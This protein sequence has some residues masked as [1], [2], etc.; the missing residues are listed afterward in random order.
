MPV[1]AVAT[2]AALFSMLWPIAYVRFRNI[3]PDND[4]FHIVTN[5]IIFFIEIP[6]TCVVFQKAI[7]R[8]RHALDWVKLVTLSLCVLMVAKALL[9]VAMPGVELRTSG[10]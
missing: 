10:R 5:T 8:P 3:L 4:V 7:G 9:L 1:V 2:A 6:G